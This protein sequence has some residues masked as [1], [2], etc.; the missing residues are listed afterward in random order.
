MKI[1]IVTAYFDIGRGHY[2]TLSRSNEKYFDYF[3]FWAC[4]KNDLTV[5]CQSENAD[6]IK[7]IRESYGLGDKTH[8]KIIDDFKSIEADM[9]NKMRKIERTQGFNNFRYYN[10]ALSNKADYDYVMCLKWWCLMD[11]ASKEDDSTMMAWLDF[12]YNHGGERYIDNND[13][14]FEWNYDFPDKINVFCLSDPNK[15]CAIDS[16][17]FQSD[18]FIGHTAIMPARLCAIFWTYIKEAMYSLISLDCID[19]DQQLVLMVYK[20]YP[21]LF[22]VTI[23]TWF[24][25]MELCSNQKFKLT[26]DTTKAN[27]KQQVKQ[28]Y[29]RLR[30][31]ISFLK[32][33]RMRTKLYIK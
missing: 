28:L 11:A 14:A 19:D 2:S 21:E 8:I 5:Y 9:Y 27:V 6:K 23:C 32:R 15:K 33:S 13:F 30:S 3:K 10:K 12:G 26:T 31:R 4:I 16:L 1:K 29:Q 7:S 18:C 25:D 24:Q 20:R 17:Q 22:H